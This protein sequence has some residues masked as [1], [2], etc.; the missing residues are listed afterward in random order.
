MS[1]Q[2]FRFTTRSI[3]KTVTDNIRYWSGVTAYPFT[4]VGVTAS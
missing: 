4:V 2:S 1:L 3:P